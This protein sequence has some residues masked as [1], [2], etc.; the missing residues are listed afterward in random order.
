[1]GCFQRYFFPGLSK[2]DFRDVEYPPRLHS[3]GNFL[4]GQTV[5]R[6]PYLWSLA[7]SCA[8]VSCTVGGIRTQGSLMCVPAS[9]FHGCFGKVRGQPP[10]TLPSTPRSTGSKPPSSAVS[11]GR[12][13]PYFP[14]SSGPPGGL[15]SAI[16]AGAIIVLLGPGTPPNLPPFPPR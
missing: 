9:S 1:M 7:M 4:I 15:D 12:L 13:P 5:S 10:N 11:H 16:G 6:P 14:D 3:A 8:S 2:Q